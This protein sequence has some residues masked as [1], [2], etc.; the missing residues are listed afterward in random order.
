MLDD[1]FDPELDQAI[2]T[3]IMNVMAAL[4]EQGITEI[5]MGGMMRLLGINDKDAAKHDSE[6]V[7]LDEAFAK[8]VKQ[9]KEPIPPGQTLH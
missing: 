8:Y 2:R 5:H 3:V 9:L 1:N 4:Y 6:R 7:I